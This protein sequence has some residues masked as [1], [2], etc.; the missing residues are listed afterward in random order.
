MRRIVVPPLSPTFEGGTLT[1][2]T[3]EAGSEVNAYDVLF[4]VR[5]TSLTEPQSRADYLCDDA[6]P[7]VELQIETVDDGFVGRFRVQPG[8]AVVPGDLLAYLCEDE[9]DIV[10]VDEAA[11]ANPEAFAECMEFTWQ[12]YTM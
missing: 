8:E 1:R 4:H 9:E 5:T 12:A 10:A 7:S 3:V 2:W 6:D 11:S